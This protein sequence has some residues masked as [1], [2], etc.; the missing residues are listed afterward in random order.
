MREPLAGHRQKATV[1]RNPHDGL[2]DTEGDDL[3]VCDPST[4]VSSPLG[5][6][7]VRRAE[8]GDEERVEVGVHRGL[9]VD[10][11]L[12]T[13]DFDHSSPNPSITGNPTVPRNR[14]SATSAVESVI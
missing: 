9:P 14:P 11:D 7:I 6:E 3:R 8:N 1:A 2:G 13:A 12:D 4:G 10:G 5:E